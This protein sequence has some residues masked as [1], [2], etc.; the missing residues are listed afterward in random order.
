MKRNLFAGTLFGCAFVIGALAI[1]WVAGIFIGT[2]NLGFG[3]TLLI[4]VVYAIGTWELLRFRRATDSLNKALNVLSQPLDDFYQWLLSL[5]P[6][7]QSPVRLR[8]EGQPNGLP[9]PAV[10]PYLVGLLVML[11]L[12]GTFVGMVDTLKGAV[13]ALEGTNE[14]EAIRAGLAAPIEGL[15][16]AFGTSVAGV[17]ASA[18]LGLLSNISRRERLQASR[19][20]DA[21]IGQELRDFSGSHQQQ[22]AFRAMRDQA[23]ALPLVAEHLGGLL[24]KFDEM[25]ERLEARLIA[26]QEQFQGSTT[27]L[28]RELNESVDQSLKTSLVESA[29]LISSSVTPMAEKTLDH[30]SD[31]A[32]QTQ[33]QLA[34]LSQQQLE[35]VDKMLSSS[36]T[37][38]REALDV[39][40]K[41][42]T[43]YMQELI[44]NVNRSVLTVTQEM[45][46]NS[47]ALLEEF[48]SRGQQWSEQ[49]QEQANRLNVT[50]DKQLTQLRDHERQRGDAAV[51]RLGELESHV[52]QHIKSLGESLEEPLTRLIE[53]ASQTPKAAAD[54]IEKL[55]GEMTRNFE[56]DNEL[57][58]ERSRLMEQLDS[59]AN[60][61]EQNS[62]GQRDAIDALVE[63]SAEAL[64][65]VGQ[66]FGENLENESSKLSEMVKHFA[67]SS[68]EMAS[69]GDAFN[70]AVSVFS[71]SNNLLIEN[72]GRIEISLEKSD[73]RSNEQLAYYVAQAR[74][75]I[76]HNLL[77]HK[78][79]LDALQM[80][81]QNSSA[82][83]RVG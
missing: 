11:G 28:Y 39:G 1:L 62:A 56:R 71:E 35:A 4:G 79:I 50:V 46:D 13:V 45:Q 23:S 43:S 77:T 55:R 38:M 2:D 14:L 81:Q 78:E 33:Q 30:L 37:T 31:V 36:N 15:G 6:S 27:E 52:A 61:L 76:D 9:A 66:Q 5:E 7:L 20:L 69:L 22:L 49:Q 42:Q 12:L 74:E 17:A 63:Q 21:K 41:Q 34:A 53:T 8:V 58:A 54:V 65:I 24:S 29:K 18:M 48:A 32:T 25:V 3:V 16:L 70:A 72:L 64:S 40:L 82:Q 59:L 75:I 80:Q 83:K 57:L 67:S 44:D 51:E 68:A 73:S 10:T 47:K 60:T 26:N 19:I